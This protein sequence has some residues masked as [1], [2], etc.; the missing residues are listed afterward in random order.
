MSQS[1][2]DPAESGNSTRIPVQQ[3]DPG[4]C[5]RL[6][7]APCRARFDGI[8]QATNSSLIVNAISDIRLT[9]EP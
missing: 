2:C 9:D 8:Y 5:V 7:S 3:E 4:G 6:S 1:L